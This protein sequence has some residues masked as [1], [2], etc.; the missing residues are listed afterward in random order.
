MYVDKQNED[1]LMVKMMSQLN[2]DH[3]RKP[4]NT[5]RLFCPIKELLNSAHSQPYPLRDSNPGS[6]GFS[7]KHINQQDY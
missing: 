5:G 6:S 1:I 4:E 2:L 7:R 3:H